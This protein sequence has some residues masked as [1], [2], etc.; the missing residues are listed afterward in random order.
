MNNPIGTVLPIVAL[1][2]MSLSV[3][4]IW[5]W[6]Q[7]SKEKDFDREIESEEEPTPEPRQDQ[8]F[9]FKPFQMMRS[10]E[11]EGIPHA[12]EVMRV[13]RDLADGSLFVQIDGKQ[14]RALTDFK[15]GEIGRRFIGNVKSLASMARLDKTGEVVS[16]PVPP[17]LA[18]PPFQASPRNNTLPSSSTSDRKPAIIGFGRK[19]IP[20]EELPPIIPMIDQ[21]ESLLQSRLSEHP[22]L[23][24]RSIHIHEVSGGVRIEVD[25]Q[26]FNAIDEIG[27]SQAKEFIR[28]ITQEW[29]SR[30]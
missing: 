15:D 9:Q 23:R 18:H 20:V 29:E 8:S 16:T 12:A 24:F 5:L 27:D 19:N 1:I 11:K 26:F 17:S 7:M 6:W 30:N 28:H 3:A 2:V 10:G 4:G 21:I 25:G 13:Y 14:Y 22:T